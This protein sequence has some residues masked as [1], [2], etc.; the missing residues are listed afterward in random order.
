MYL[1]LN[2]YLKTTELVNLRSKSRAAGVKL[3]TTTE[4][5][6]YAKKN[7]NTLKFTQ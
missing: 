4:L 6:L 2:M 3:G 5:K 7:T 1:H